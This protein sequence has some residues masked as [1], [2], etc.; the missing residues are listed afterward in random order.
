MEFEGRMRLVLV[1]P[2]AG[3]DFGIQH[4]RGAGYE[5]LFV[6]QR[7]RGDLVLHFSMKVT[8]REE[9]RMAAP[10]A[11]RCRYS[12]A[13]KS[14]KAPDLV[15]TRRTCSPRDPLE[16]RQRRVYLSCG[17]RDPPPD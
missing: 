6:Q 8:E 1:D 3:I 10:A 14:S 9:A 17:G 13:G 11:P 16:H 5:T 7:T 2:P 15:Y 12:A 4:G